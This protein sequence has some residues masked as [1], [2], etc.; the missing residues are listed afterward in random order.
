MPP[1]VR[2]LDSDPFQTQLSQ[3]RQR[4]I[5]TVASLYQKAA[6]S[7]ITESDIHGALKSALAKNN[8][9][10]ADVQQ[11]TSEKEQRD[12]RL[13]DTMMRLLSLEKKLDRSKS[14]TLAKIEAQA[15]QR[16]NQESQAEETVENGDV[17]SRPESRVVA[18]FV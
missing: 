9:L 2:L 3:H 15:I 18:R 5:N 13:T 10:I 6:A 4:V 7:N 14:L 12:E 1:S 16:A 17:P 8:L 11:L